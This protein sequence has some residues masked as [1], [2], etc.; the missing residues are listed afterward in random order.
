MVTRRVRI[1]I[2]GAVQGVGFRPFVYRL[3]S[4]LRLAGWVLNSSQGVFIE[5][6]AE[7]PQLDAFLIRLEKER[8]AL[9]RIQSL[10]FSFLDAVGLSG[11]EIRASRTE[12]TKSVQVLPDIATC[13]DCLQEILD[14][15]ARRHR[16]PFTNCTHCGPRYTIIESLPYDRPNTSMKVFDM[17]PACRE[18]YEDPRDRRFHAQPIACPGCGPQLEL[19]DS[20]GRPVC[21]REQALVRAAG[22]VAAGMAVAVKGLGGFHLVADARSEEA[23]LRLR[24]RK[25]RMEK[26]LALMFPDLRSVREVCR[27]SDFEERLLLSPE[28]PIVLLERRDGGRAGA[29]AVAEPVAPDNPYLGIML[30]Y[31]PLHH[32]LMCELQFPIVATSGNL[33]EEPICVDEREAAVR[34]R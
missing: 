15:A 20:E 27:V 26:P 9:S 5:A 8:P 4:E 23:V 24:R 22:A 11:F 25:L 18:E 7:K 29:G 34:L 17:C 19:W 10:E 12:G 32:L 28:S 3:A 31:T 1:A 6:E 16:Y 21:A 2:R 33:S 14:P 30:P 13:R